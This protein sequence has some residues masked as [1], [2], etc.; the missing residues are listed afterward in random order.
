MPDVPTLF[1]TFR[2]MVGC[3]FFLLPC[4]RWLF[5]YANVAGFCN[6]AGFYGWPCLVYRL[7]WLAAELGWVVAEYGRQPWVVDGFITNISWACPHVASS[8]MD[9][10][11]WFCFLLHRSG[12]C[13]NVPDD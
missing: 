4:L 11:V 2:V 6:I 10:S 7:P 1:W 9:F 5:I 13:G 8:R 12:R 3:G